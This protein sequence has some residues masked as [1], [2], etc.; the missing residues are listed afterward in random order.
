MQTS[1]PYY[2]RSRDNELAASDTYGTVE[3]YTLV[4]TAPKEFEQYAPYTLALITLSNGEKVTAP[5]IDANNI[6]I[7]DKVKPCIRRL[8]MDGSGGLI[9][10][11]IKYRV[12]K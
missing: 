10:Y 7:G 4:N 2:W 6:S 5:I 12:V 11:G 9:F 1:S 8:F 3:S